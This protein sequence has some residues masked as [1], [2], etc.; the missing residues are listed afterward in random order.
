MSAAVS[1]EVYHQHIEDVTPIESTK[2]L[3][4]YRRKWLLVSAVVFTVTATI[5]IAITV[6]ISIRNLNALRAKD[7]NVHF[8]ST[9]K[10]ANNSS[11]VA[12]TTPKIVPQNITGTRKASSLITPDKQ[13]SLHPPVY[14]HAVSPWSNLTRLKIYH[15]S[16]QGRIFVMGDIHG[17]LNEMNQLLDKIQFKPDQDVLILAGD[18]VFR[19]QD[20]I[21]VIQRARELNALCVRGNHD[22]K[23]IRL[24]T[25]EYQHGKAS[26][27]PADEIM[28][29]GQVGDP[30]KFGNKHIEISKNLNVEDYTYLAGCPLILD[31]PD[32]N[33]RVVHGGLDPLISNLID[34]DP[35]S[36]MNMRDMD[37]NNQPSKLKLNKKP[38]NDVQ[39]WTTAYEANAAKTNNQVTVYY[40][41]DASRGIVINNQT[42]GVDSGCVYGRKLSAVEMRSRELAQVDCLGGD[43]H[44]GDDD[45]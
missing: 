9:S 22:D 38:G 39:H 29:E 27:S 26:M 7:E 24:K 25:Y 2:H 21:G 43:K 33:T 8:T 11:S 45:D 14:A 15:P 31:I 37:D 6:P 40:G 3:P 10:I 18:L 30:L 16:D 23:V 13:E 28:P 41:H 4:I 44:G 5:V 34:N 35:W 1:K 20:S 19:G 32:L 17:C 12:T 42:V 36:V